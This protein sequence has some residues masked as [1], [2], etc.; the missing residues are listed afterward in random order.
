MKIPKSALPTRTEADRYRRKARKA[1]HSAET[2]QSAEAKQFYLE[3]AKNYHELAD[4]AERKGGR[5]RA[6]W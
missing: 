2:A 3:V 1:E 4:R 5:S 6:A